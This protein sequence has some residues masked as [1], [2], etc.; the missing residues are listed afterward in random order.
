MFTGVEPSITG[1]ME[2][3]CSK[4]HHESKARKLL[5]GAVPSIGKLSLP[6]NFENIFCE[7]VKVRH[8]MTPKSKSASPLMGTKPMLS[9]SKAATKKGADPLLAMYLQF[10]TSAKLLPSDSAKSTKSVAKASKRARIVYTLN[11]A[12]NAA[13]ATSPTIETVKSPASSNTATKPGRHRRRNQKK[14]KT[15]IVSLGTTVFCQCKTPL[16]P[17][18]LW[19]LW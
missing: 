9:V 6:S 11:S 17:P 13:S 19:I 10:D 5:P 1:R 3:W 14:T 15:S 4:T 7:P 16:Y 2:L 12:D 18:L 8:L